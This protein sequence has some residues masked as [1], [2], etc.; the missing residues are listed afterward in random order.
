MKISTKLPILLIFGGGSGSLFINNWVWGNLQV[1]TENFRVIHLTGLLQNEK[2]IS[3]KAFQSNLRDDST[4]QNAQNLHS[5]IDLEK[6]NLSKNSKNGKEISNYLSIP[7]LLEEMPMILKLCD[8]V[9]CRAGLSSISELLY[10]NKPSFLVPIPY[11]HQEINAKVVVEFFPILEQKNSQIWLEDIL[12]YKQIFAKIKYPES[13]QIQA[14][15]ND[16]YQ[17]VYRIITE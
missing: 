14:K 10:L 4:K 3:E 15:L 17:K 1:L 7:S 11:S 8:L 6:F 5:K 13:L 12:N 2:K 9:I 16:Y